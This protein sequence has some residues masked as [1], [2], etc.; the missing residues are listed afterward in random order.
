M[1]N[2]GW[3][4]KTCNESQRSPLLEIKINRTKLWGRS[5]F[6]DE[7]TG[8]CSSAPKKRRLDKRKNLYEI[9]KLKLLRNEK[10]G[11]NNLLVRQQKLEL[12][13]E[14]LEKSQWIAITIQNKQETAWP[15][16]TFAY[17]VELTAFPKPYRE[18]SHT[19][20]RR[21]HFLIS[22]QMCS[23]KCWSWILGASTLQ[24][25]WRLS[26]ACMDKA[27]MCY[28]NTDSSI[29]SLWCIFLANR[30][31]IRFWQ[32]SKPS[33]SGPWAV[34]IVPRSN[35]PACWEINKWHS[36]W[37]SVY[38]EETY[39]VEYGQRHMGALALFFWNH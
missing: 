18:W 11:N 34:N 25:R 9:S 28:M 24:R 39:I 35:H 14:P 3:I 36:D 10:S 8:S 38:S 15:S 4:L 20:S 23:T 37:C 21:P 17:T 12:P 31:R 33:W 32:I 27:D 26:A 13:R 29:S 1:E 5:F 19:I 7:A 22:R 16:L 6:W 30:W 2:V